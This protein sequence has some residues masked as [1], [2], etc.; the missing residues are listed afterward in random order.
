VLIEAT[1]DRAALSNIHADLVNLLQTVQ[2][3]LTQWRHFSDILDS[4]RT[5][6]S[7]TPPLL[8]SRRGR[9]KFLISREQLQY[10]RSLSFSWTAVA[11]M[12]KVTRMTIYR[13]RVEYHMLDESH[14]RISDQDLTEAVSQILTQYPHVGQTFI[15]GRLRSLGYRVTRQRIRSVVHSVDPL[16]AALR[17]QG[18]AVRRRP[19][20]VPGPNSL[21]HVGES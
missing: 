16:S 13:R 21:W 1:G 15:A 17:W 7:Y 10:L 5:L 2:I 3:S 12:F 9:P 8:G 20:S 14:S 6:C 11:K 18:I 4:Q 19:Y